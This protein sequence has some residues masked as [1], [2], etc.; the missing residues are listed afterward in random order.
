MVF[1]MCGKHRQ[2]LPKPRNIY[3]SRTRCHS[4]LANTSSVIAVF[5]ELLSVLTWESSS[6]L[7][8]FFSHTGIWMNLIKSFFCLSSGKKC[9]PLWPPLASLLYNL[10]FFFF[11]THMFMTHESVLPWLIVYNTIKYYSLFIK[12]NLGREYVSIFV[13]MWWLK[14][15]SISSHLK[16]SNELKK[17]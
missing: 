16:F 5:A 2:E 11:L 1:R 8:F 17:D 13:S 12:S 4:S 15:L 10:L 9:L 6:L 3:S 7:L 14:K